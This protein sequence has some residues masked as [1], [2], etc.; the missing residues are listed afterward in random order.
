VF[1]L[2]HLPSLMYLQH[3]TSMA[4]IPPTLWL[5]LLSLNGLMAL[6]AAFFFRK[7]GFLAPVGVHFWADVVWHVI[8]GVL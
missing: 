6:V 2:S 5:E 3:W 7:Y 8:W 4:Q 1:G